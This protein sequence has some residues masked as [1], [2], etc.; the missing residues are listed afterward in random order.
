VPGV[1]CAAHDQG[2]HEIDEHDHD[3]GRARDVEGDLCD[4]PLIGQHRRVCSQADAAGERGGQDAAFHQCNDNQV[5]S[6]LQDLRP[7]VGDDEIEPEMRPAKKTCRRE[8]EKRESHPGDDVADRLDE[9]QAQP[10]GV[11]PFGVAE[12]QRQEDEEGGIGDEG[13][14]EGTDERRLVVPEEREPRAVE[15]GEAPG[16]VKGFGYVG[17]DRHQAGGK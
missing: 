16:T 15:A 7:V 5:K 11:L 14:A 6:K 4:E 10:V 17:G 8:N 13:G 3:R 12:A 9:Q 2:E 1:G